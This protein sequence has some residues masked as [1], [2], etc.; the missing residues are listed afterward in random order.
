MSLFILYFYI[1]GAIIALLLGVILLLKEDNGEREIQ[2]GMIGPIAILSWISVFLIVW[3]LKK[4]IT[5]I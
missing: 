4:K 1:S 5:S 3:K 2:E